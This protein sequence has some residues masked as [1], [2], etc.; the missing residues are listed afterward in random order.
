M[1]TPPTS[2]PVCPRC[3]YPGPGPPCEHCGASPAE[4]RG[5]DSVLG[6]PLRGPGALLAGALALPRGLGLLFSDR[7]NVLLLLPPLALTLVAYALA[8]GFG[9]RWIDRLSELASLEEGERVGSEPG[10][11]A[12]LAT[13]VLESPIFAWFLGA[14][15]WLVFLL[16]ALLLFWWTFALVYELVCGPF[17]DTMQARLEARWFGADPR[18][19]LFPAPSGRAR[20]ALR[21]VAVETRA[22]GISLQ[23]SVLAAV[24]FVAFLPLQLVPFVGVPLFYG[25]AGATTALTLLD[26]PFSRRTWPLGRRVQF[27]RRHALPLAAFGATAGAAFLL[28]PV[29]GPVLMVP[30]ASLGGLW[31]VCRLDKG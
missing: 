12:D 2:A 11:F 27:L 10:F 18:E 16:L 17:L 23:A 29:V 30:G 26:I 21:F 31:L 9:F 28:V 19:R 5:A 20:R 6:P 8:F 4:P 14:G 15:E 13:R 24:L 7:R 22:L 3:G 1:S 25:L